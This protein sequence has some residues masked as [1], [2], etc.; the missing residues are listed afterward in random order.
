MEIIR[1]NFERKVAPLLLKARNCP[2]CGAFVSKELGFT[3]GGVPVAICP[4]CG[5]VRET[6]SWYQT[7]TEKE[8][9]DIIQTRKP[10]GLFLFDTGIEVIGIDNTT[11]DA[12]VK[13]FPDLQECLQW[14]SDRR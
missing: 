9:V 8:A 10:I 5:A 4:S 12:W 3:A 1:K 6:W 13:E 11:G 2:D 14:L 7:V